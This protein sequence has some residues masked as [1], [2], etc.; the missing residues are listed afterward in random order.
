MVSAQ[1]EVNLVMRRAAALNERLRT[2]IRTMTAVER[3]DPDF[4]QG[5]RRYGIIA[6]FADIAT[7]IGDLDTAVAALVRN[8]G[9]E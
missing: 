7:G 2:L 4:A 8:L 3:D 6:E 5:M 1:D 9:F